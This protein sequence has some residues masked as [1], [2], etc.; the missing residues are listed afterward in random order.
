M[1][2]DVQTVKEVDSGY[3]DCQGHCQA[4]DHHPDYNRDSKQPLHLSLLGSTRAYV[5]Q[6]VTTAKRQA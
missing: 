6:L 5:S 4:Q 2:L 3:H 1:P